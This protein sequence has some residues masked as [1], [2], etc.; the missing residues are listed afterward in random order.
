[1]FSL[2]D[3]MDFVIPATRDELLKK[4]PTRQYYVTQLLE[5]K[6][7]PPTLKGINFNFSNIAFW[8]F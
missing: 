2:A 3:S 6:L 1:M 7:I 5:P 8:T 4:S